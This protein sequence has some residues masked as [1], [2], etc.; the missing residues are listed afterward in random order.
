MCCLSA[1]GRCQAL[2]L[3]V[4]RASAGYDKDSINR[5]SGMIV[6][7]AMAIAHITL[8]DHQRDHVKARVS[9]KDHWDGVQWYVG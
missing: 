8:N 4:L 9:R 5:Y 7:I 2:Q 3:P 6:G 1:H